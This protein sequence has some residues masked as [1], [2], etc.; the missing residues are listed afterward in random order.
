MRFERAVLLIALGL[1]LGWGLGATSEPTKIGFVDAQQVIATAASGKAAREELERK[2]REAEGRIAP[3]VQEYETKKKELEAKRFVMSEDAIKE[4]VLDLQSLE[5]R[6]KG[7]STEE[8][9]KME[10]DQQR[11]FGPLQEKFIEVVRE[12]GRENGFSAV[13]LS[14]SPG[15][16]YSRE[17]LDLTELVIKTF[18]KKS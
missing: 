10:I 6:I 4:K 2:V 7:M 1:A 16:V 13:M 8:Q 18:D 12:V 3:L 14:D 11:L 15:L 9:G 17:A 5:N